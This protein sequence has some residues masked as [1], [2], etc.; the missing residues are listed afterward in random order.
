M[1]HRSGQIRISESDSSKRRGSQH[2]TRRRLSVLPKEKARLR[3]EISV[4]PAI[5]YN[6][7]DVA[8]R[9]KSLGDSTF[10]ALAS[11]LRH[12]VATP[13]YLERRAVDEQALRVTRRESHRAGWTGL[14]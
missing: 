8:L 6:S 11:G 1:V 4:A 13:A 5:Q 3:I 2:F 10:M 7:R 12:L 14:D 9:I